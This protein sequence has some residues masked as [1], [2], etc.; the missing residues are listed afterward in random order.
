MTVQRITI[1]LVACAATKATSAQPARLLYRS[2]LFRAA[3]SYAA[4]V[5][6]YWF[7]LSARHYLVHPDEELEPYDATLNRMTRDD[8]EH[9]G[10]YVEGNLRLGHGA[11]TEGRRTWPVTTPRLQAAAWALAAP[12]G[13]VRR[14]GLWFHAGAAYTAPIIA[15]IASESLFEVHTPLA[16]L[17]IG[18]QLAWYT[19]HSNHA[20]ERRNRSSDALTW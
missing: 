14:A 15:A 4:A 11:R 10:R 8:R 6:D 19:A 13:T 17:G 3:S 5:Y 12:E 18:Q 1:G 7:V 16:G 20:E 9:W 2:P